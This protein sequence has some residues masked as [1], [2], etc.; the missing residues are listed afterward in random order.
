MTYDPFSEPPQPKLVEEMIYDQ[1]RDRR[2]GVRVP[3]AR[4]G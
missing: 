4:P 3:L 1:H 2:R